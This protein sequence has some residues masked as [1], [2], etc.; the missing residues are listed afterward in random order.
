[1][2]R[3]DLD[4][5]PAEVQGDRPESERAAKQDRPETGTAQ[6]ATVMKA[7]QLLKRKKTFIDYID[8]GLFWIPERSEFVT[9]TINTQYEDASDFGCCS[10]HYFHESQYVE[11]EIDF[12]RRM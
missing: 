8:I 1:M 6:G 9:W 4:A 5:A 2:E 7:R 10:G 12:E 11:A 3:I